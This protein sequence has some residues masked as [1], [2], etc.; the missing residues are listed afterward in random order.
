MIGIVM[1]RNYD[2]LG[3]LQISKRAQI[4]KF[5]LQSSYSLCNQLFL[6]KLLSTQFLIQYCIHPNICSLINKRI[7]NNWLQ[8]DDF[9]ANRMR[10]SKKDTFLISWL[11]VSQSLDKISLNLLFFNISNGEDMLGQL[12]CSWSNTANVNIVVS[13]L[14]SLYKYT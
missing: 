10:D 3:L 14:F 6:Y 11:P 9:I 8:N 2:Q 5:T 13:L 12:C 1:V 4:N 7:Y